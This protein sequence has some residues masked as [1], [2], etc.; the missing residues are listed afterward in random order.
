MFSARRISAFLAKALSAA[1][2]TKSRWRYQQLNLNTSSINIDTNV[3]FKREYWRSRKLFAYT[4]SFLCLLA[5]FAVYSHG[6]ITISTIRPALGLGTSRAD[7]SRDQYIAA[8]L[9]EPVEGLVDP[10]PIRKKCNETKFQEGLVWHCDTIVGGIGNVAN[11]WLNCAR[12][13][14][15]AGG[16]FPSLFFPVRDRLTLYSNNLDSSPHRFSRRQSRGSWEGQTVRRTI[17]SLRR[18]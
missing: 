14:I 4:A 3:P 13:A 11:M 8:V 5:G 1:F 7:I 17:L 9:K 18:L 10:D 6:A 12:Y 16:L 2:N 15:E